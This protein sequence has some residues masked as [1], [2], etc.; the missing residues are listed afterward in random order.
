MKRL[1]LAFS[2]AVFICSHATLAQ[3]NG[4]PDSPSAH[5]GNAQVCASLRGATPGLHGLC[6]AYCARRDQSGVDMNDI[7]S[8]RAAAPSVTLLE[9]YNAIKTE[10]DPVMPCF[11]DAGDDGESDLPDDPPVPTSCACWTSD[12]IQ[13]IDGI[14]DAPRGMTP[15][16][17]CTLNDSDQG[18][19][20]A[21]VLEG[22][23][24]GTANESVVGSAFAY[25]DP[26]DISVQGC[27]FQ[28]PTEGI[29][30]FTLEHRVEAQ[31]CI[32]TIVDQCA[33]VN[34]P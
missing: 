25:F 20:E 4:R 5:N 3:D 32:Q 2:F 26:L 13:L 11:A 27:M 17:Q 33:T 19:Y 1:A 30:N 34:S 9:R 22:Y 14:L 7:A 12:Q 21:Q 31:Y 23:G 10:S 28:S 16:V 6:Q 15:E 24:L 8:V 18:I 29:L